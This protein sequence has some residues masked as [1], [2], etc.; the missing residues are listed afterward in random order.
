MIFTYTF[1]FVFYITQQIT[2]ILVTLCLLSL[3]NNHNICKLFSFPQSDHLPF[4][5]FF[6][7]KLS[8]QYAPLYHQVVLR[9]SFLHFFALYAVFNFLSS[10]RKSL[11]NCNKIYWLFLH[12]VL[13]YLQTRVGA[14]PFSLLFLFDKRGLAIGK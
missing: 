8:A 11:Y 5:F 4:P 14:K 2:V 3:L 9:L 6:S 12:C 1:L 10:G 7:K 13:V